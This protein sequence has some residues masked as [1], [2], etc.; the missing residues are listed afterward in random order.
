MGSFTTD[1]KHKKSTINI[2]RKGSIT[3]EK[4]RQL[5]EIALELFPDR[6]VPGEDLAFL[7]R[8]YVG[9]DKE[10]VRAYMGYYGSVKRRSSGEGYV[11]GQSRKGH[12]EIFDC[13]HRTNHNEWVIHAQMKLQNADLG[14]HNN[15]GVEFESKEKISLS[16]LQGKEREKTVLEVVS[17]RDNETIETNNNNNNTERERNFTPKIYGEVLKHT[18]PKHINMLE[19]SGELTPEELRVLN[20][21]P[22]RTNVDDKL[23]R[24]LGHRP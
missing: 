7:I 8:R 17:P 13:M 2:S 6:R 3:K 21:K 4:C 24:A 20:A 16:I 1:P 9:G 18:Y 10:T 19:Q 15:E 12:L 11:L 22:L 23:E 14:F 5:A